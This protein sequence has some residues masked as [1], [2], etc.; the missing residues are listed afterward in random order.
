MG[1][2]LLH[3]RRRPSAY[4]STFP[5]EHLRIAFPDRRA[6]R[7][8]FKNLD[9]DTILD[10]ASRVKPGFLYDPR[11][12]INVYRYLPCSELGRR[13]TGWSLGRLL[14]LEHVPAPE[15]Y[16]IGDFEVWLE[17]ARWLAR[18]HASDASEPAAARKLVPQ[19]LEHDASYYDA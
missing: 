1:E 14:F 9:R 15:L 18:L 12:E 6:I 16:Q 7:V 3:V 2:L 11:R 17:A 4:S 10:V 13:E 5:I 8:I 19:L